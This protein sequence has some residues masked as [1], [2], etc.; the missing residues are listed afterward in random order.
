[1]PI[2]PMSRLVDTSARN[3]HTINAEALRNC[4]SVRHISVKDAWLHSFA[5]TAPSW[6]AFCSQREN[7]SRESRRNAG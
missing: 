7:S 2:F 5:P 1:M 3:P 6:Y 4:L